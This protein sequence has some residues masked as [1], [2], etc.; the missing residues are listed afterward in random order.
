MSESG[1]EGGLRSV[2]DEDDE[3]QIET[4]YVATPA[5]MRNAARDLRATLRGIDVEPE[6]AD[7]HDEE[8]VTANMGPDLSLED[9][10]NDILTLKRSKYFYLDSNGC[11]GGTSSGPARM[12]FTEVF[13]DESE[14]WIREI[15]P[16]RV[17]Q[18]V[19]GGQIYMPLMLQLLKI[20]QRKPAYMDELRGFP[21]LLLRTLLTRSGSVDSDKTDLYFELIDKYDLI[22][23]LISDCKRNM[24]VMI[25]HPIRIELYYASTLQNS[26]SDVEFPVIPWR[27]IVSTVKRQKLKQHWM[28]SLK[29]FNA[30]LEKMI[31]GIRSLVQP[32][33]FRSPMLEDWNAS[34]KTMLIFCAERVIAMLNIRGFN[35]KVIKA[36]KGLLGADDLAR[37]FW[38]VPLAQKV[39]LEAPDMESS[40][41]Q[42]GLSPNLLKL[43][44]VDETFINQQELRTSPDYLEQFNGQLYSD[45]TIPIGYFRYRIRVKVLFLSHALNQS[46]HDESM[47]D[48]GVFSEPNYA[49]IALIPSLDREAF[50]QDL[51]EVLANCY[52]AEWW[53]MI[54]DRMKS[55][56]RRGM[57]LPPEGQH[58]PG[59]L[60][61]FPRT[62]RQFERW[63]EK[64]HQ[65]SF[66]TRSQ[67][68]SAELPEVT[69]V[70]DFIRMAF[71]DT[72]PTP[73][74]GG[75]SNWDRC[76]SRRMMHLI[77]SELSKV[78][79]FASA[80]VKHHFSLS[81]FKETLGIFFLEQATRC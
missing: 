13:D 22:S 16:C 30:P 66:I 62:K 72:E 28:T 45:L 18:A 5:S 25:S 60:E 42:F 26:T 67:T 38:T 7:G 2:L 64:C 40:G 50:L 49:A 8:R 75:K 11:I 59:S 69:N 10:M 63:M 56:M 71:L 61:D 76:F 12:Q 43:P 48:Y 54:T 20:N 77:C 41:L 57:Y 19:N 81:T 65:I 51:C 68:Y 46:E 27:S 17:R 73:G 78:E 14:L 44:G 23:V 29:A 37:I 79:S 3:Q 70:D 33:S 52:H 47:F 4:G 35:G 15:S 9:M 34:V 39:D 74:V 6:E 58:Y 55:L 32:G 21:M 31:T 36:L 1:V 24:K 53:Y 80:D